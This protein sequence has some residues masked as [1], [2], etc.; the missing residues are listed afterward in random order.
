[1][2]DIQAD[3]PLLCM[4]EIDEYLHRE[5]VTQLLWVP[6]FS[7]LELVPDYNVASAG[8]D[9]KV[10]FWREADQLKFPI[11]G[12]LLS[13]KAQTKLNLMSSTCLEYCG[14]SQSLLVGSISGALCKMGGV[15]LVSSATSSKDAVVSTLKWSPEAVAFRDHLPGEAKRELA[16]KVEVYCKEQRVKE[17][18]LADLFQ[19][20]L[21]LKVLYPSPTLLSYESHAGP[22]TGVK[23]SPYQRNLFATSSADGSVRLYDQQQKAFLL[24]VE[25]GA[26]VEVT[27][28]DWSP[29]RPGAFAISSSNGDVDI[30]DFHCSR[31]APVA[32]VGSLAKVPATTVKFNGRLTAY[33]AAGYENGTAKVYKLNRY[34]SVGTVKPEEFEVWRKVIDQDSKL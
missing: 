25:P 2:W 10:L 23:S 19:A 7:T 24:Q 11:R 21:N 29:L 30:Y 12:Y 8:T 18:S 20:K 34:Y 26:A 3:E 5:A 33:M 16:A 22:V 1:M 6:V 32:R 31:A 9:G 17:V 13:L 28:V 14:D 15:S 27:G 4:S